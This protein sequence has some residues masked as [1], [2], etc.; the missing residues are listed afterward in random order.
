MSLYPDTR[1]H[2][3]RLPR[4]MPKKFNHGLAVV[5]LVALSACAG[6]AAR[7]PETRNQPVRVGPANGTLVVVGGGQLGPEIV[8]RFLQAAG[9]SKARIVII[10]TAGEQDTFPADW[11]GLRQ[12]REAGAKSIT[13]LHTRDPKVA[14]TE[15]FVQ[16]LREATGV[17]FPGGRQWRLVDSYLNTRTLRE[18]YNLLERGGAIGGTSAGASIQSSYMVRGAREGNTLVMAAGYEQGFGFLRNAA[19]DQHLTARNRQRDL[20]QVVERHQALLGIGLDESTAIVVRG[21]TAEIIGKD[22]VAFYNTNSRDRKAYFW[23]QPGDRFDLNRRAVISGTPV[24]G[25]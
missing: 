2:S 7:A 3:S 18:L 19:V 17:W 5:L 14:D 13:V 23:L 25:N 6:A 20:L 4:I 16:P 11:N 12:F 24:A 9:G 15:A 10:P 21:D 8:N 1:E 22:R